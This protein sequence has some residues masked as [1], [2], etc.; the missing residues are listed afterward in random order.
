MTADGGDW[1]HLRTHASGQERHCRGRGR[2]DRASVGR[3]MWDGEVSSVARGS[4]LPEA[5]PRSRREVP[6]YAKSL[7]QSAY[8]DGRLSCAQFVAVAKQALLFVA[9]ARRRSARGGA[10]RP[11]W[12]KL[13]DCR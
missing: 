5:L 13:C 9:R 8:D 6:A 4:G 10:P 1:A 12:R 11:S 2:D 3:A 7:L